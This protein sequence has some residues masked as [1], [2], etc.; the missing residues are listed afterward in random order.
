M[1]K[2]LLEMKFLNS[3]PEFDKFLTEDYE[4]YIKGKTNVG[5]AEIIT[6]LRDGRFPLNLKGNFAFYFR[7]KNRIVVAVD[8]LP[9]FQMF[10][11]EH[12][13]GHIFIDIQDEMRKHQFSLTNNE[14]VLWQKA[15]SGASIGDETTIEEIKIV[16][17][18]C[19][20]EITPDK[21][22]K[23]IQYNNIYSHSRTDFNLEELSNIIENFI[24][25]NTQGP[26][27]LLLSSGT[28][29]NTIFGFFR[30]LGIADQCSF[31]SLKGEQEFSSEAPHTKEIADHYG[32][33]IDWHTVDNWHPRDLTQIDDPGFQSA[34][35]RT[36]PGFWYDP[37]ILIKY[38]AIRKLG[39]EN[40]TFFTGEVGDQIFGSRYG[41]VLLKFII[42][43]PNCDVEE[44]A[45]LFLYCDFSRFYPVTKM[46]DI[47]ALYLLPLVNTS[48]NIA[49]QWFIETWNKIETEDLV[50]KIELMLYFYK[51]SHRTYNYTQFYDLKFAH[52][53]ADGYLFDYI[54][55]VPGHYKLSNGGQTRRLSYNLIKDYMVDWPWKWPKTGPGILSNEYKFEHLKGTYNAIQVVLG[56][57]I[58]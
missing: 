9:S 30:K 2:K 22:N 16:P 23:I 17:P 6:I 58:H 27:G 25:E 48:Y 47:S 20:L 52:P 54:W 55:R 39:H 46:K 12:F 38:Y 45:D 11:N 42:Q 44:I 5:Y 26:F 41:R 33:N 37:H 29:S 35:K 14:R 21:N 53:F 40:K 4:F 10:Y 7:D 3:Q 57:H 43:N 56:K 18:G 1:I 15:L 28:D 36:I 51:A 13:C 8:H 31:I 19:Y 34:F 24:K 50:N 49:K 32:I